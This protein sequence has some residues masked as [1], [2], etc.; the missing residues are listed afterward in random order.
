MRVVYGGS[1][2]T[3]YISS[4]TWG[5][6]KSE[7]ARKLELKIINAPTDRNISQLVLGLSAPVSLFDDNGALLFIGYI[8][9]REFSSVSGVV[10]Y[11]A[12]DILFYTS[13]STA[14]YNFSDKTAEAITKMVCEDMEIP[15]NTLAETGV[16]QKLI[17]QN[18]T[19]YDIIKE[20]YKQAS[21]QTEKQ[22]KIVASGSSLSVIEWGDIVCSIALTEDSN[23]TSSVF[24][25]SLTNMVN[26]V[27]IYD[28]EGNPLD[29]VQNDADLKY[30][31]FQQVYTKEEG[32]D[33]ITTAKSMF[34]GI[35]QT[36]DLSCINYSGAIT[37]YGVII[38]DTA[39]RMNGIAWIESDT[40]TWA[41][42]VA[43][44]SLTL[45]LKKLEEDA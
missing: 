30:G 39:I 20:A 16:T 43:T 18:K 26:K 36:F 37:G 41:N 35:T 1:D 2:I 40:H 17:V 9:D 31:I 27:R 38:K 42:G 28:G 24:K 33:P 32:K 21:E 19:I 5:G 29:V 8:I 6:S 7:V 34:N 11:V 22:Y 12:Y 44:M 13:K 23:I 15:I 45:S 10:T 3:S 25:E 4:V 14:T